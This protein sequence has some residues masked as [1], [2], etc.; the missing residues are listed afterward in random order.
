MKC[1]GVEEWNIAPISNPLCH[2]FNSSIHLARV[3]TL[4]NLLGIDIAQHP[5]SGRKDIVLNE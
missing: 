5:K 2:V 3:F 4:C 1:K